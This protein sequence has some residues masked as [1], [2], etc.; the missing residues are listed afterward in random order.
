M[1]P[2]DIAKFEFALRQAVQSRTN[3]FP[4]SVNTL[5]DYYRQYHAWQM[6]PQRVLTAEFFHHN[7]LTRYQWLHRTPPLT[8]T[9]PANWRVTYFPS[10]D[11]F[12]DIRVNP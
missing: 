12:T 6:G 5:P 9:G 4:C 1:T 10:R 2:G 8:A 3:A 7:T 11:Q